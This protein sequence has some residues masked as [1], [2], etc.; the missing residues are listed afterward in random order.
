MRR[1]V[2][3]AVWGANTGVGKT[4]ISAGLTRAAVERR[5]SALYL[6]P[7]QTGVPADRADGAAVGMLASLPHTIGR[8]AA[9]LLTPTSAV[10]SADTSRATTL[11][12]WRQPVSP[13]VAVATEGRAVDDEMLLSETETELAAFVQAGGEF[14]LVETAG[15][16]ASPVPSGALQCTALRPLALPALLV[17]DGRLGGISSTIC[18]SESLTSRGHS[19]GAVVLLSD[20]D[21]SVDAPSAAV[22]A[23]PSA[24]TTHAPLGNADALRAHFGPD[25]PPVFTLRH[26]TPEE[27]LGEWYSSCAAPLDALLQRVLDVHAERASSS[28]AN[29]AAAEKLLADDMK[30]LWHPYTSTTR[31]TPCLPVKAASGV[32]LELSDGSTLIDGMSSWWAAVHGYGVP[33]LDA[34]A[35]AQIGKMSHV[36]F[37][38][39]T[40]E[41][42]VG[43]GQRLVDST[44][45]PLQKVFLCDSGSVSVEVAIKMSLQYWRARGVEG[46]DRMLTVRGGYHGDTFGAMAV[47]DPVNGMHAQMF[48]GVL[49]QHL[50]APRP[51]PIFGEPCTDAEI[52]DFKSMLE[53]NSD[54]VAAVILEPIVQGAGGMRFYSAAYLKRVRELCDA[55]GTLLILDCIATGFGRTG[56]LFACEH[57]DIVPDIMCVGKA[58]TGGYMT[59]GATI[60]TEAVADGASGGRGSA[61]PIPLMHGPTFMA[62]PLAC[63]VA[64][65]SIDLLHASPW[66]QRVGDLSVQLAAELSPLKE[67]PAVADVRTLGAIGVVEM[68]EPLHA[69][70]TQSLLA[71]HGVWLRPFGKLLYTMPPFVMGERDMGRVTGAMRA[72]VEAAERG[73]AHAAGKGEGEARQATM[74]AFEAAARSTVQKASSA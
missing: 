64:S 6:K 60:A 68:A 55:H 12:A 11:F 72:V 39:L 10:A 53:A 37:G 25:G 63:A 67:S 54:R 38:G 33:E 46:R 71:A 42:A 31:P 59:L 34:A 23:T 35:T 69:P 70:S 73:A 8:H 2:A 50:F 32:R 18:A 3:T 1:S 5:L 40:H 43:L 47:C 17:G 4:L 36:M 16:V 62:N 22:P 26:P 13:H 49:P 58:L 41:S 45:A 44:P 57:A 66:Q 28:A 19:I 52:A 29:A 48:G 30:L 9:A 7:V 14:A 61:S 27:S 24:E 15:G 20:D 74:E 21:T 65:A 51:P 56:K